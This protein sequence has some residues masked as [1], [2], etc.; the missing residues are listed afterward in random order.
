MARLT[1]KGGFVGP[2]EEPTARVLER[3]LPEGWEV[4]FGKNLPGKDRLEVDFIVIGNNRIFVIEE[5]NWS[6]KIVLDNDKWL[7]NGQVRGN[8]LN[9]VAVKGKVLAEVLNDKFPKYK[10]G[11][12][13]SRPIETLVIMSNKNLILMNGQNGDEDQSVYRLEDVCK[14]LK[15]LDSEPLKKGSLAVVR[16]SIVAYLT[17][18]GNSER[19][20]RQIGDFKVVKI[21]KEHKDES[22][23]RAEHTLTGDEVILR[24]INKFIFGDDDPQE[25]LQREIVALNKVSD[26][27]RT[28]RLNNPFEFLDRNWFC[29]PT[30][31]P[32]GDRTLTKSASEDDP[33]RLPDGTIDDELFL[34][35]VEDGFDA[36]KCLSDEGIVHRGLCPERI[37]LGKAMRVMFGEFKFARVEGRATIHISVGDDP[38]GEPFRAPELDPTISAAT[39]KSDIFS[40]VKSLACWRIGN[41]RAT[42]EELREGLATLPD[43]SDLLISCLD[44]SPLNRPSI[45]DLT[46]HSWRS[47]SQPAVRDDVASPVDAPIEI[48]FEVGVTIQDR[49]K[50][51]DHLGTGGAARAWKVSDLEQK[52]DLFVLK[53]FKDRV[54]LERTREEYKNYRAVSHD[55][56]QRVM[57]ISNEPVPGFL[58]LEYRPGLALDEWCKTLENSEDLRSI[59]VQILDALEY[60]RGKALVHGDI[61]PANIVVD[62][63]TAAIID[64]GLLA[65]EGDKVKGYTTPFADPALIRSQRAQHFADVYSLSISVLLS[66]LGRLPYQENND[67][68]TSFERVVLPLT[69]EERLLWSPEILAICHVFFEVI[70]AGQAT[71]IHTASD[72]KQRILTARPVPPAPVGAEPLTNPT[73]DAVRAFY[74]GSTLGNGGNR[75]MESDFA[76][77]T[78]VRTKLDTDLVPAI[79]SGALRFV[80]L[81]GNPGDGKTA[82]LKIL[83]ERL[84]GEGAT[85]TSDSP[86]RWTCIFEG[87]TISALLD[88]SEA[89]EDASSDESLDRMLE[90]IST[91][92][93]TALIA[94]NDGRLIDFFTRFEHKYPSL[95]TEVERV[96]EGLPPED[97]KNTIID[98]KSR[99]LVNLEGQGLARDIVAK[100]IHPERWTICNECS[101]RNRCPILANREIL[102]RDKSGALTWLLQISHFKGIRRSTIRDFRSALSWILTG[103]KGCEDIHKLS[104][105]D[106][107]LLFEPNML[108]Y[109]LTFSPMTPD[110]LLSEWSGVDPAEVVNAE[111]D[112]IFAKVHAED[113]MDAR[114]ALGPDSFRRRLLFEFASN[115]QFKSESLLPYQHLTAYKD[116]LTSD[117]LRYL[118]TLLLGL[119]RLVGAHGYSG[120]GLA[121]SESS[122]S[123]NWTALKVVAKDKFSLTKNIYENPYIESIPEFLV[124]QHRETRAKL[125]ISLDLAELLL[126]A[127]EGEMVNDA[128]ISTH[129]EELLG[130]AMQVIGKGFDEVLLVDAAS[131]TFSAARHGANI[132]LS[133]L[134]HV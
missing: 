78:Y 24:C 17:G 31:P 119:S 50:V 56:I 2:G 81:T 112:R 57:D 9:S 48:T 89:T 27:N 125:K 16:P 131:R 15:S 35:T 58:R 64:L 65:N 4:I 124:L 42:T 41:F 102:S 122:N 7:V 26:E 84:R 21:I 10:D 117:P 127:S 130:F 72:L 118:S 86:T 83:Q 87:R 101:L 70:S 75:G 134:N 45:S 106:R 54:Q 96:F 76:R 82:F 109:D 51:I 129:K 74:R 52:G 60:L 133:E 53:Q 37:W 85:F 80:A 103:D 63:D 115:P 120:A 61:K 40:L 13:K 38:E 39:A 121:I 44:D 69:D 123:T 105:T 128:A 98:L 113:P 91:G 47:A 46:E 29:I 132:T 95:S 100:T 97:P 30:T 3:D 33:A 6:G 12:G 99:T 55:S 73:V 111:A 43:H 126:R 67:E 79:L 18:G 28:W 66:I 36:L 19:K 5:K 94:A 88:A 59:L 93:Y 32:K 11:P 108:T 90:P 104:S 20:L 34:Q 107:N 68:S 23:F 71:G 114:I 110:H 62:I 1:L 14:K 22:V 116:M 92:N 77:E 25:F 49:F 8:P